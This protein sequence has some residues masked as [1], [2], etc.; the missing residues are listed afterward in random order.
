MIR[1][2]AFAAALALV[3]CRAPAPPPPCQAPSLAGLWH[4]AEDPSYAYEVEDLGSRVLARPIAPGGGA[5]PA[6]GS[7]TVVE[8]RRGPSDLAGVVRQTGRYAFPD[9][10][11]R[12]CP[13]EFTARVLACPPG[14]LEIEVEQSGA[15]DPACRRIAEGPPDLARHTWVRE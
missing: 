15:V 14:R 10:T 6:A 13:V 2:R 8:L 12:T 4:D 7:G 11:S 1:D 9:G 5:D 3:A